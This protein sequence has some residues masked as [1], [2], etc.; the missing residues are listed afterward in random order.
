MGA[1]AQ[2]IKLLLFHSDMSTQTY[3]DIFG[4][5]DRLLSTTSPYS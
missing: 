2:K 1:G 5:L 3:L 4:S